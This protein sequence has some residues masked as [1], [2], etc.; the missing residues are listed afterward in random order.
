MLA[1]INT[2]LVF[3]LGNQKGVA[4]VCREDKGG[5]RKKS[6]KGVKGDP[7]TICA[8]QTSFTPSLPPVRSLKLEVGILG[9]SSLPDLCSQWMCGQRYPVTHRCEAECHQEKYTEGSRSIEGAI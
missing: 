1:S 6:G 9:H 8:V 4:A 5:K 7:Q 3:Y 2:G